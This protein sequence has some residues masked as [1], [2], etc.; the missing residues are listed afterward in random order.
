MED[1]LQ[2]EEEDDDDQE[3]RQIF[4]VKHDPKKC[5]FVQIT[6]NVEKHGGSMAIIID[7]R[8]KS[9]I[10]KVHMSDDGTG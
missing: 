6:R 10:S 5:S 2:D 4:L 1:K 3:K 9:D 7:D 8:E